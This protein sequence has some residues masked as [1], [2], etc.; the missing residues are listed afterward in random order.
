MTTPIAITRQETS[1]DEIVA[2]RRNFVAGAVT[3]AAAAGAA[4]AAHA[5]LPQSLR[6]QNPPGLSPPRG[7]SHVVEVPAPGRT[8]YI[9]GQTAIDA[10]GKVAEGFRAQATQEFENL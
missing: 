9:A 7:Y 4:E 3:L 1:V 10:G 6:Y 8:V 5:Q 2:S